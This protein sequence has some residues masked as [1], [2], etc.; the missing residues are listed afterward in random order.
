ME[1]KNLVFDLINHCK[2][3]SE[4]YSKRISSG[5]DHSHIKNF[6]LLC[7]KF[8]D[9]EDK[10]KKLFNKSLQGM[11]VYMTNFLEYMLIEKKFRI[12]TESKTGKEIYLEFHEVLRYA[13]E[14]SADELYNNTSKIN[15]TIVYYP[16]TLMI[17]L[18]SVY[19]EISSNPDDY[20]DAIDIYNSMMGIYKEYNDSNPL[21]HL[22]SILPEGMDLTS[23]IG[24]LNKYMNNGMKDEN[25]KVLGVREIVQEIMDP[26]MISDGMVDM[27]EKI[28]QPMIDKAVSGEMT[29]ED[30]NLVE[31]LNNGMNKE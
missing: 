15:D 27:L 20:S 18:L 30:V 13:L 7:K 4:E 23:A 12:G 5:V 9:D 28:M 29:E 8:Q 21:S 6:G 25:G 14:L 10:L 2:A 3:I 1:L 19:Q 16:K 17:K 11:S 24:K 26:S 22:A 31:A